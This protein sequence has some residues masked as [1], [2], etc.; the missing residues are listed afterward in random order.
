MRI[1]SYQ[2]WELKEKLPPRY[3]DSNKGDYGKLLLVVGSRNMC[4]AA[5]LAGKAAYRSGVGLV[6][7]YT[8]EC[9]RVILQELLPE[10][11]LITYEHEHWDRSQLETALQGKTAV[12]AG[13]GLG[14]SPCAGEIHAD[15]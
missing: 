8:E 12:A 15:V 6:Y 11:V 10:A 13:P 14:Q 2:E 1:Q 7:I 3:D 4:G 5:Y 9:N